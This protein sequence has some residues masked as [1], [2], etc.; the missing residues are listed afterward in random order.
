MPVPFVHMSYLQP[1]VLY[2]THADP[3]RY[4]TPLSGI[5]LEGGNV[6]GKL[7]GGGEDKYCGEYVQGRMSSLQVCPAKGRRRQREAEEAVAYVL[8]T[9]RSWAQLRASPADRPQSEQIWCSQIVG[10]V[11]YTH[12]TLPTIYSV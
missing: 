2:K 12:L 6:W 7:S 11:S 3:V 8:H 4:D 10:A 5:Q 1:I 9:A